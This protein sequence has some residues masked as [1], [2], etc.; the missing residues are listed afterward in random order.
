[1]ALERFERERDWEPV[2]IRQQISE[3]NPPNSGGK[4]TQK[5]EPAWAGVRKLVEKNP[6]KVCTTERYI[7]RP[8]QIGQRKL[9]VKK[10]PPAVSF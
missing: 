4:V 6:S 9:V 3:K 8:I 10:N 1:M 7:S 5:C 2:W